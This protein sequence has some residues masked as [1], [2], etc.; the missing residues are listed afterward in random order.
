MKRLIG[1]ILLFLLSVTVFSCIYVG[2]FKISI[3][4]VLILLAVFALYGFCMGLSYKSME[5]IKKYE[6]KAVHFGLTRKDHSKILLFSLTTLSP[7]YFCVV[8]VSLVPLFTYEVWLITVL[9]CIFLNCLPAT[10]VLEEYSGLTH[11]KLPFVSSFLLLTIAFCL[12]GV[13]GSAL[14]T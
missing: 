3:T 12:L 1:H 8:L 13:I 11:Q 5:Q 7:T 10:S 6:R 9:P 14:L 2:L 4:I